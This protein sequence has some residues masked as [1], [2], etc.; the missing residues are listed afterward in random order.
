MPDVVLR[1][2]TDAD[3]TPTAVEIASLAR[4]LCAAEGLC[5]TNAWAR[6]EHDLDPLAVFARQW[7]AE[8]DWSRLQAEWH[9]TSDDL[10]F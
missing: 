4:E 9:L 7:D 6:A 5:W 3:L 1:E 8:A 10:P 2:V